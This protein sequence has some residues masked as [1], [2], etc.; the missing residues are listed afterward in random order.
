MV[1]FK[2]LV[3]LALP[4]TSYRF[5]AFYCFAFHPKLS[6]RNCCTSLLYCII[7]KIVS[8]LK[9]RLVLHMSLGVHFFL[10]RANV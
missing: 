2:V 5:L 7:F 10:V 9:S 1:N 4:F 6:K 8:L 3:R